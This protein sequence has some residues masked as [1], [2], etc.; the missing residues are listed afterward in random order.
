MLIEPA[1]ICNMSLLPMNHGEQPHLSGNFFGTRIFLQE[2]VSLRWL[3]TS[4]AH[5]E[6]GS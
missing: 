6:R 5:G 1:R 2:R 4:G 3:T